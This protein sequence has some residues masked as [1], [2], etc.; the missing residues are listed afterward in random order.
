M[1][2]EYFEAKL[3]LQRIKMSTRRNILRRTMSEDLYWAN[4]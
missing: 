3:H 2:E 1:T 4:C